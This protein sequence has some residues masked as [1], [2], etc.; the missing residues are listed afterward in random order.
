M[1]KNFFCQFDLISH[2]FFIKSGQ[3][4]LSKA[5]SNCLSTIINSLLGNKHFFV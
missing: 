2:D 3:G 1:V 4:G 5:D